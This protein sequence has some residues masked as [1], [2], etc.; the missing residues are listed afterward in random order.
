MSI[1]AKDIKVGDRYLCEFPNSN[2]VSDYLVV[3]I[4]LANLQDKKY[5][6]IVNECEIGGKWVTLDTLSS[7]IIGKL[8]DKDEYDLGEV[9]DGISVDDEEQ[10]QLEHEKNKEKMDY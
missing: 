10:L 8:E 1:D 9:Y 5:V 7:S 3:E 2:F 6:K 4:V